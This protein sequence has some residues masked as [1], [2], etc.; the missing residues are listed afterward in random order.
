MTPALQPVPRELLARLGHG[1]KLPFR[2]LAFLARNPSLWP[3][4]LAPVLLAA[5]GLALGTIFGW[6]VSHA[7]LARFWTEPSGTWSHLAWEALHFSVF[8][9]L[10]I[11]AALLPPMVLAA[12]FLDKLSA[13]VEART[14]GVSEDD[15]GS[16]GRMAKE[17]VTSVVHALSRLLR[18]GIVQALLFAVAFIP[19]VGAAYPVLAFLWSAL[20][21]A[22]ASVDQSSA[23]H[24]RPWR[25]TARELRAV[26]PTGFAMGVVLAGIFLIPLANLFLVPLA[27]VAGTLLY[28]DLRTKPPSA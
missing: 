15:D 19:V 11:S 9:V 13:S 27:T 21:L 26:R 4:A 16:L 2:A 5:L 25:E 1:L 14:L 24:L 3:L 20:W 28:G 22:E 18:F 8:A 10:V 17:T 12:P 6:A 7:L 23:R